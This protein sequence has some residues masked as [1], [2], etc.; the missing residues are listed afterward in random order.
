[1]EAL[2]RAPTLARMAAEIDESRLRE[3][4][5]ALLAELLADVRGL[6]AEQVQTLLQAPENGVATGE[7]A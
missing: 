5:P 4:D 6:S 7:G 2:F 3:A 1:M